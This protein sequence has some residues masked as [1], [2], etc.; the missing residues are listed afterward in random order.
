MS[1]EIILALL[2]VSAAIVAGFV[3]LA[4]R[5]SQ[6]D[7]EAPPLEDQRPTS[8]PGSAAQPAKPRVIRDDEG[9]ALLRV[10]D[11]DDSVVTRQGESADLMMGA[12][13]PSEETTSGGDLPS[14]AAP[15][16]TAPE[17]PE[18][19]IVITALTSEGGGNRASTATLIVKDGA[20]Y[21]DRGAAAH[22]A[23]VEI[24]TPINVVLVDVN[25]YS[26]RKSLIQISDGEEIWLGDLVELAVAEWTKVALP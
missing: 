17:I 12:K 10:P 3:W 13:V 4:K 6:I 9:Q 21:V 25:T 11:E 1:V 22:T 16:S 15:L 2:V 5:G 24:P 19:A 8:M 23:W 20:L 14:S 7:V 26:H 18:G